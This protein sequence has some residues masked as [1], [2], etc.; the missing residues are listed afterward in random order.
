[1]SSLHVLK[2]RVFR[3]EQRVE[4]KAKQHLVCNCRI[5]TKYHYREDLQTIIKVQGDLPCPVHVVRDLGVFWQTPKNMPL[6]QEDRELCSCP[7]NL[8]RTY[9]EG[10]GPAPPREQTVAEVQADL[11]LLKCDPKIYQE[12]ARRLD[13]VIY[14]YLDSFEEK[15][16]KLGRKRLSPQDRLR[17]FTESAKQRA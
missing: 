13:A 6:L 8:R 11:A 12:E 16:A 10:K 2:N 17:I 7:P 3:L 15:L 5:E 1:M 4:N 9:L 14:E